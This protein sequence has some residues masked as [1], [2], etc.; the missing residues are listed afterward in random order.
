MKIVKRTFLSVV[1]LILCLSVSSCSINQTKKTYNKQMQLFSDGLLPVA[2]AEDKWG[3]INKK[4][5]TKIAFAYDD[6]RAFHDGRAI[7]EQDDEYFLINK[8][9]RKVTSSYDKLKYDE[10]TGLYIYKDDNDKYGLINKNDKK[11]VDA[12]YD[13]IDY[14]S[15]GLAIVE[16]NNIYGFINKKGKMVIDLKYSDAQAFNCGLA[17]VQSASG[18]WGYVN[19]KGK[20]V[21]ECIYDYA[22]AFENDLASYARKDSTTNKITRFV[23]NSKGKIL[24]EENDKQKLDYLYGGYYSV[25]NQDT[26]QITVYNQKNHPILSFDDS[27]YLELSYINLG[28]I[29]TS[30]ED[31]FVIY[32]TS[33]KMLFDLND[34]HELNY[35]TMNFSFIDFYD[36]KI[37]FYVK[38]EEERNS[39]YIKGSKLRKLPFLGIVQFAYK[40]YYVVQNEASLLGVIDNKGKLIIDYDEYEGIIIS[41][42]GFIIMLVDGKFTIATLKGQVIASDLEYLESP[43]YSE[44][45]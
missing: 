30:N 31:H 22:N 45:L 9:G 19:Q 38:N 44:L 4:G 33:G 21:V 34:H 26:K 11:I 29:V 36:Q 41:S 5:Q 39:Y 3:F 24:F 12:E 37:Y 43:S 10:E 40:K 42:D 17:P 13:D 8:K 23:I 18:K 1:L 25:G 7:V 35:K 6:A 32:N 27:Y 28:I 20:V 15:E 2:N 16:K 14:F